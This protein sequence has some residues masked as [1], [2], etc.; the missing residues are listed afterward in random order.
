MPI[1]YVFNKL[2]REEMVKLTKPVELSLFVG[3]NLVDNE[4]IRSILKVYKDSSNNFLSIKEISDPIISQNF[5]ITHFPAIL[6]I[7]DKGKEIIRYLAKPFGPEIRS[8]VETLITFSGD[9][10]YYEL[11]IKENINKI[12]SSIIKVM[13]TNSCAYCPEIISFVNKFAIASNGKIR[14]V[15]IDIMAHPDISE[16]YDVSSVPYTVIND[17]KTFNGMVGPEEVLFELIGGK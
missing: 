9:P 6:F 14:S 17:A 5:D 13:I 1:A 3:T 7:N 8:F 12:R 11:V 4:N 10:N 2:I 16:S 15:I